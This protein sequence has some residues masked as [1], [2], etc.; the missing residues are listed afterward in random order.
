V[1]EIDS[2]GWDLRSWDQ[3]EKEEKRTDARHFS[4][5]PTTRQESTLP[6]LQLSGGQ[7]PRLKWLG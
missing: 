2:T 7:A 3:K 4:Y 1:E 5:H 6:Q